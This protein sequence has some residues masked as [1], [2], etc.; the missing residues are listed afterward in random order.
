[1]RA[2]IFAAALALTSGLPIAACAAEPDAAADIEARKSYDT[3]ALEIV[4]FD[5]LLNRFN[6]YFT[7][8][9][10]DYAVSFSSIRQNLRSGWGT[11]NDPFQDEP[12][13]PSVPGIDVPRLRALGRAELLGV[14][15]LYVRG[16][17]GVGDRRRKHYRATVTR[18]HQS[19]MHQLWFSGS[20][21]SGTAGI[22]SSCSAL[23]SSR[24]ASP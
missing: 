4:G 8:G 2:A 17:R 6:R 22:P 18:M 1:M 24:L 21:G 11:D 5:I 16:Q 7:R 10:R 12:A 23:A 3:P 19:P 14:A 13:R 15:R 9:R 20:G